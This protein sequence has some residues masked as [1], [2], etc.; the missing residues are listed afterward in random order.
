MKDRVEL[1]IRNNRVSYLLMA[2]NSIV[3]ADTTAETALW[4]VDNRP[5]VSECIEGFPEFSV[6]CGEFYLEGKVVKQK[7]RR[8]KDVVCE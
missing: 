6:H 8:M 3:K 4:L 2:G 5:S 7:K 1:A